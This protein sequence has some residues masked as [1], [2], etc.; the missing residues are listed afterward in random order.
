MNVYLVVTMITGALANCFLCGC[1][2]VQF[3]LG[4]EPAIDAVTGLVFNLWDST[5]GF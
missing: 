4:T 2:S 3:M 5:L 1:S